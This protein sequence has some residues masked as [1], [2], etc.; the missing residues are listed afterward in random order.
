MRYPVAGSA[1][2]D[3]SLALVGLDDAHIPVAWDREQSPY[4]AA[5]SYKQAEPLLLVQTRDQCMTEVRRVDPDS[6]ETTAVASD[7]DPDWVELVAGTPDLTPDT[8]A[9]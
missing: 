7:H 2:A 1:N 6:G 3:V 9:T 4:L 5:V 8:P